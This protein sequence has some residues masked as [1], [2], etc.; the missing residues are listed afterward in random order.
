MGGH[1]TKRRRLRAVLALCAITLALQPV[2]DAR[3]A[4]TI[5]VPAG[6]HYAARRTIAPGLDTFRLIRRHP[7]QVVNIAR[8][9]TGGPYALRPVLSHDRLTEPG[10]RT[11]RT[12]SMCRRV[13]CLVAVNGDFFANGIPVGG[14]VADA[15]LMRSP[16]GTREQATVSSDGSLTLGALR[17]GARLITR[18]VVPPS[19][20]GHEVPLDAPQLRRVRTRTTTIA[21]VNL[22]RRADQI[23]L[24]TPRFGP[25]TLTNNAGVEITL[26]LQA[27]GPVRMGTSMPVRFVAV[28]EHR[29]NTKI[30]SEAVVLSG[31]GDGARTLTDLWREVR[32][33]S[34]QP[35]AALRIDSSP[36]AAQSVAGNPVILRDGEK[37]FSNHGIARG[38]HPRTVIGWTNSG[39][40][41]L[42][43]FDG[44][45]GRH[46]LGMT[47]TEVARFMR[48]IGAVDALNLDGGGSTT[49][50]IGGRVANRPSDRLVRRGHRTRVVHAPRRGD[51]VIRF[52][53]RPVAEALAVV[54]ATP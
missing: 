26:R 40:V 48:A 3:R 52:V 50:V 46:A 11:E 35:D 27:E 7:S 15:E 29:G 4:P 14:I 42:V 41:L 53:E 6:Y 30:P 45:Q 8:F 28:R 51:R 39:Q 16:P 1:R 18:H 43:T 32:D 10:R 47:L 22:P 25:K 36:G 13:H 37:A 54:R 24:Y 31:H 12:S 33:G 17:V 21:G 20:A 19:V 38:H 49:F 34:A 9:S 2:A 44:R 5:R 23:V